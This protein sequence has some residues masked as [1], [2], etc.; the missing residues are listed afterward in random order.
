MLNGKNVVAALRRDVSFVWHAVI[1]VMFIG[2]AGLAVAVWYGGAAAAG[3]TAILVILEVSLSFDNAV[4]N[5]KV[6]GRLS[7]YWQGLFLT[8][9]M[10]IAVFGMRLLFPLLIVGATAHISPL[11][12]W[13]L[14]LEK[15][16]IHTPGT[17]GYVLTE[18]HPAIAA[19][20]RSGRRNEIELPSLRG[21]KTDEAIQRPTEEL[22]CFAQRKGG[23][24]QFR[25]VCNDRLL[26][27]PQLVA[28]LF[29]LAHPAPH[30]RFH[31]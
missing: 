14:A 27:E 16:D 10:V 18:A 2:F 5:A 3:I 12:A 22:D 11:K 9:G 6:L 4:V 13:S 30:L 17:Y 24:R 31:S 21:G 23:S 1:A 29:I 26:I 25:R 20:G 8:V 19:D 28:S 7:E 15:G